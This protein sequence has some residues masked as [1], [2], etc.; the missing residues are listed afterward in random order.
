MKVE[1]VAVNK[2]SQCLTKCILY[3]ILQLKNSDHVLLVEIIV[4]SSK[5]LDSATTR[6]VS[7]QNL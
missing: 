5:D 2:R 4:V 3:T 7:N 1:P 6:Y